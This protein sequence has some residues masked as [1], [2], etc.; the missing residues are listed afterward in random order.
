LVTYKARNY[1]GFKQKCFRPASELSA[2]EVL[3]SWS[4]CSEPGWF[5]RRC[6]QPI[7]LLIWNEQHRKK[8]TIIKCSRV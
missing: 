8:D 7:V 3:C 1:G 6:R 4:S 2:G 5:R